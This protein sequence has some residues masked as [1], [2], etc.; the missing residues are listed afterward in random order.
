[1]PS[2]QEAMMMAQGGGQPPMMAEEEMAMA[3]AEQAGEALGLEEELDGD[4]GFGL[5]ASLIYAQET[6]PILQ[7][8]LSAANPIPAI[9]QIVAQSVDKVASKSEEKGM[10]LSPRVWLSE[11]GAVDRALDEIGNIAQKMGVDFGESARSAAFGEVIDALKLARGAKA[12]GQQG[13]GGMGAPPM[14]EAPVG[15][16]SGPSGAPVGGGAPVPQ[17]DPNYDPAGGPAMMGEM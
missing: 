3:G 13:G 8:A 15:A 7:D 10:P 17:M 14:G 4:I 9:A 6:Q 2:L 1:M 5:L 16:P 11:G 12:R